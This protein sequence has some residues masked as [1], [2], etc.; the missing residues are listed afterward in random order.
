MKTGAISAPVSCSIMC[1][2]ISQPSFGSS[3]L[4]FPSAKAAV[5]L[6]S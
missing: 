6:F 4:P 5:E 3:D 2:V 1:A